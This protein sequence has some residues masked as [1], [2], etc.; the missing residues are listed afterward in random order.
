[1]TQIASWDYPNKRIHLHSDTMTAGFDPILA[2]RETVADWI[3]TVAH[4]NYVCAMDAEGYEPK[5]NSKFTP[6]RGLLPDGWRIVPYNSSHTLDMLNELLVKSEELSNIQCFDRSSHSGGVDVNIDTTSIPQVEIIEVLQAGS[7]SQA[8]LD[9]VKAQTDKM[10]FESGRISANAAAEILEGTLSAGD[11][12]R[13][14]LAMV[15]GQTADAGTAVET[16]YGVDRVTERAIITLD[17]NGNRTLVILDA[18]A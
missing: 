8:T 1:M 13:I 9:A 6:R 10:V 16:F 15:S 17:E 18:A 3:A 2:Y 14:I 7:V 11:M 12:Q 5:G 4:Q